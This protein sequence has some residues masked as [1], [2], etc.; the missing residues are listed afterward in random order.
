MTRREL[1]ESVITKLYQHDL[2]DAILISDIGEDGLLYLDVIN[3]KEEIDK[4][5]SKSLIGYTLM[6]LSIID[7]A[8]MRLATYEMKYTDTHHAII[9]NEAIELTKKFSDI[10]DK[11]TRFNNKLLENIKKTLGKQ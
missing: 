1:R 5:I 11:Q 4:I 2:D 3:H 7:R 8:I 10:D 9:I 6:R